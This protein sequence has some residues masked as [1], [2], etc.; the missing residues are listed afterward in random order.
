[1][2]SNSRDREA[3]E[4]RSRNL[5][6]A[7]WTSTAV[8]ILILFIILVKVVGGS[9]TSN[10][11]DTGS[12]LAPASLLAKVTGLKD[13]SFEGI[14]QG[15]VSALPK[16]ITAPALTENGKPEIIYIGAEYCPYCAT[17]RWPMVIALSRFGTFSNLGV[18][19]SASGDVYPSTQTFSFHGATYTS[20]YLVFHGVETAS[21]VV[22]GNSYKTLDTPT[23]TEQQIL[24]T[25]NAPPYVAANSAG[26]IPFVDF[27]GK[28][29]IS[30]STY[31]PQVLQGKTADQ[32]ADA[33][34]DP[35]SDIYKGVMGAANTIIAAICNLT[36]NLP[37]NVCQIQQSNGLINKVNSGS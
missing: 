16:P 23:A 35:S 33:L 12:S 32:I 4:R 26:A 21:N 34:N 9:G 20:D 8:V 1:M 29:L 13:A 17:E 3:E 37:A 6:I 30:G 31:S 22:S 28:Y 25:Y 15:S 7:A 10:S 19:H 2:S 36:G 18:T 11:S 14:G 24:S 5:R 27:G